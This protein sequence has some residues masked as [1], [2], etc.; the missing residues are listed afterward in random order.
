MTTPKQKKI[1]PKTKMGDIIE[2]LGRGGGGMRHA[3]SLKNQKVTPRVKSK[4]SLKAKHDEMKKES[5]KAVY[6]KI[7]SE[8]PPSGRWLR[9]KKGSKGEFLGNVKDRSS[10]QAPKYG[11]PGSGSSYYGKH[12][13]KSTTD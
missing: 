13:N 1:L 9:S 5:K 2:S 10:F 8:Q 3:K 12:K 4:D 11:K 6:N 7:W